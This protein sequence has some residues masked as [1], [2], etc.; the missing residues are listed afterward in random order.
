MFLLYHFC[1]LNFRWFTFDMNNLNLLIFNKMINHSNF[2]T[3]SYT[4]IPIDHWWLK[5]SNILFRF[6]SF[7]PLIE[8]L[9]LSHWLMAIDRYKLISTGSWL[10]SHRIVFLL[11]D[12]AL[13]C[14]QS[15]FT[16][17]ILLLWIFL[18]VES[19]ICYF[20]IVPILGILSIFIF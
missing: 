3:P 18:V 17:I 11:K 12:I 8:I 2:I 5:I 13:L 10:I 7:L 9:L 16:I 6:Y 1:L 14:F 19:S 4:F 20:S 15:S